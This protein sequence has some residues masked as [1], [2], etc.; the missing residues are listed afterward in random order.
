M[1]ALALALLLAA[2]AAARPSARV[3]LRAKQPGE[4][5]LVVVTGHAPKRPPSG[6]FAGAKLAFHET[7]PGEFVAIAGLDLDVSTGTQL[8]ELTLIPPK[9]APMPWREELKV[10]PKVFATRSLTVA[11]QYAEPPPELEARADRETAR[12]LKIFAEATGETGI[13]GRFRMPVKG[14]KT[15]SRFGE[16][17]VFNGK[18]RSPHSGADIKASTGTPIIAPQ[19][20]TVVLAEDLFFP[21]KTLLLDHGLGVYS[22]FAHLSEI[23][24][25]VGKRV[26]AGERIALAGATGRV[27]GPHLHWAVKVSKAR[28][29]PSSVIALPLDK[30]LKPKKKR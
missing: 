30:Y 8:V 7:S 26:K 1:A 6:T 23:V 19:G 11:S 2:P 13:E 21:G 15:T 24:V 20:G 14:A 22:F 9:G 16:R 5:A 27:T 17:S 28:V 4:A 18:P 3:I 29:D 10:K 25:P 12:L